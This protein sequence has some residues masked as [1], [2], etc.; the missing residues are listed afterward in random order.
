MA[1]HCPHR[2]PTKLRRQCIIWSYCK[3]HGSIFFAYR[4]TTVEKY[5]ENFRCI[6]LYS[7]KLATH[8]HIAILPLL[9]FLFRF[10]LEVHSQGRRD[11]PNQLLFP[12]PHFGPSGGWRGVLRAG[13]VSCD[14]SCD[15][16]IIYKQPLYVL[17]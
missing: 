10:A 13:I 7:H 8:C 2:S 4:Y 17:L 5:G 11:G 14:V 3:S 6:N 1:G 9:I 12:A 16:K 15:K